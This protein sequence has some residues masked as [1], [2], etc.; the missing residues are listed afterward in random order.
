MA[1]NPLNVGLGNAL[2]RSGR[3]NEPGAQTVCSKVSF[4]AGGQRQALYQ[5]CDVDRRDPVLGQLLAAVECAEHR[6][7]GDIRGVE[8]F[9]DVGRGAQ[10]AVGDERDGN[11]A[12]L[13]FL[14]GFAPA[15]GHDHA[16]RIVPQIR[17]VERGG[18]GARYAADP[19]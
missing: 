10:L 17:N 5:P 18:F 9:A 8:S 4:D 13:A 14:V 19:R 15:Q 11:L 16:A 7:V 6:A 1:G 12:A 3:R 2:R